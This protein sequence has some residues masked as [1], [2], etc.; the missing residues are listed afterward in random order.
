MTNASSFQDPRNALSEEFAQKLR[1]AASGAQRWDVILRP[2]SASTF[3]N[4]IDTARRALRDLEQRSPSLAAGTAGPREDALTELR[5]NRRLL[6]SA[7]AAVSEKPRI[8]ARLPRVV[9]PDQSD[10]PRVAAAAANYL[11]AVDGAFSLVTFHTFIDEVQIHEPLL[12]EELWNTSAFLKF[13]V[14]EAL[15]AETKAVLDAPESQMRSGIPVHIKSLRAIGN[16][17]WTA[18][19]EGLIVFDATLRKDPAGTYAAMDFE[20][21]EIYRK[22][23]AFISRHSDHTEC[24]VAQIA[25]SLAQGCL[26]KP[27]ENDRIQLRRVHVGFYLLNKGFPQLAARAGYHPPQIERIRKFVNEHADFFY[28]TCIQLLTVFFIAALIATPL[29][30]SGVLSIFVAAALLILPA[31]QSAVDLV[32]NTITALF[33]PFPIPKLDFSKGI[34][35]DCATMVAVPTLLLNEKQVRELIMDLEV[36]FLA[37]RD[38]NLHFAL[39][40]DLP[41]SVSK[42]RDKDFDP[43]VD[44]AIRLINDLNAKYAAPSRGSFVFLHR[45]RI[46]NHKQGA[47]MGWERK[48]GK[49]LDL[50]KLMA[51]EFDAFPIKAGYLGA[52]NKIRYVLTLDSDTQLP[53]CS[54]ARLIGAIAHPLSQAIIHPTLRIVTD[55]YGILQP[56]IGVAV[57]SASRSRLASIYSGQSGFDIYTRAVSDAYQDLYGEGIFTGKGIYEAATVNAVLGHRFPP[58]ALLSHDLIEGAYA[59]AGLAADIELIDDYPSHLS[60]YSRRRHR[61]VRGDWQIA[62]WMFGRVR[63]ESNHWVPNPISEVSRWKIFDNLRRSL[64]EPFTLILFVAGWIGLPGGPLYWTLVSL[65][66]LVLPTIVQLVFGLCR[67]IASGRDGAVSQVISGVGQA[68]LITLLNLVFLPHQT[69]LAIDAIIRALVRQF[70]TGQRLLEWETAAEAESQLSHRTPADRYLTLTPVVSGGIAIA[71][72]LA[73]PHGRAILYAAPILILWGVATVVKAWLNAPPREEMKRLSAADETFLLDHALLIWRFFQQFGGERHNFLIPDNVEED[74]LSEAARVSPTNVGLLLNARQAGVEFGFLTVPEF[75]SLTQNSLDTISRLKKH[76]GHLLNWYDTQTLDPLG[77]APFI[78]S[79][80]SGNLVASL[81]T[82]HAGVIDL[83]RRPLISRQ[84]FTGL[85]VHWQIMVAQDGLPDS[86]QQFHFPNPATATIDWIKWLRDADHTLSAAIDE[87]STDSPSG[88][89][90]QWWLLETQRRV[91]AALELVIN[92]VPWLHP[93]YAPLRNLTQFGP[94]QSQECLKNEEAIVY[95]DALSEELDQLLTTLSAADPNLAIALRLRDSLPQ[96]TRNLRTLANGLRSLGESAEALADAMEF[97][98]LV[99]PGRQLLSI[100]YDLKA[101]SLHEATYDML[102]SEARIA[103]FLAV[104]RGELPQTSWF[105]LGRDHTLAFGRFLLLSWTGTMFEYLMPTL[106]MRRYHD[107]LIAN[108]LDACVHVQRAFVR[109]LRIPWGI[110][111]SGSSRRD[112]A[113]HYHYQAYGVPQLALSFEATAGPIISPYSSFLALGVDS[114]EALH[115]LR[116]MVSAGWV[117]RYGFYEAADYS[118][119]RSNP[120]LVREWM[121][122]HQ[123][124]S[125][126]AI[127]NLLNDNIVQQWFHSSPLVQSTELLLHEA[128]VHRA[129]L[130]AELAKFGNAN[131][132]IAKPA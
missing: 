51:G 31:S 110:S 105:K 108:T 33:D 28:I 68:L 37:N 128:P 90:D 24:D 8:I 47:W 78:S 17:D 123:G 83:A 121:A 26:A 65:F 42:P 39:L 27:A 2:N 101:N 19:T 103:T 44:L 111:E 100:G 92:Y 75:I 7:I 30:R 63:D 70:I 79:V 29:P 18:L 16:A 9:L 88:T 72:Y 120:I 85:R 127:L 71:V 34:P 87:M 14:L 66:L 59:R 95:A 82:L 118:S 130:R 43:L 4:R 35:A 102:A 41:D 60:A 98:F 46:F 62:P 94:N 114:V 124:M 106:W 25:L 20:S 53:R 61:W 131:P 89:S 55:G 76:R 107:T 15:L 38:P 119:S 129:V 58:N 69:L 122:H 49:L 1:D 86:I 77:N 22:R 73:H 54:A 36:R 74:G 64:V 113:G 56:R 96:A 23:V 52:I 126:L 116:R 117:G 115:N 97:G 11:H 13:L 112:D 45:H 21:R 57:Q 6:R 84:L 132:A 40:T 67:S 50:N 99:E 5:Q 80:D 12:L 104:A 81:H 125:L 109:S 48:R 91:E 3:Q 10:E 93:D 32:N